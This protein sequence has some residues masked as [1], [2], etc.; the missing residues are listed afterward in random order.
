MRLLCG[1]CSTEGGGGGIEDIVVVS[2]TA[3]GASVTQQ[4]CSIVY[5]THTWSQLGSVLVT[6]LLLCKDTMTEA[7]LKGGMHI[8]EG[9]LAVSEHQS[10]I[11]I[12]RQCGSGCLGLVLEQQVRGLLIL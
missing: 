8:I 5:R 10:I 6:V 7:N 12:G 3:A 4:L 11:I 2:C 9:L 1:H